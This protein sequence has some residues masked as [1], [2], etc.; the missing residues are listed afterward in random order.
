MVSTLCTTRGRKPE[1]W[2]VEH[3]EL[4]ITH[5]ATPDRE[6][7]LLAA[8]ERP[9]GLMPAL[10]Q[11]RKHCIDTVE[12][13]FAPGMGARHQSTH[14]KIFGDSERRE[15][16]PSLRNLA[17]TE[18]ADLVAWPSGYV[19]ASIKDAAARRFVHSGYGADERALAGT[20][21]THDRND[22][23]L[24]DLDPDIVERLRV[25]VVTHRDFRR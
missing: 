3:D 23:T 13:A 1:R 14:R 18:I 11:D 5:Q 10:G 2:L 6:H 24:L 12:I 19:R 4:R 8:R 9:G 25:S 21:G 17:D 22:R 16:L 15:Y 20:I 7:L